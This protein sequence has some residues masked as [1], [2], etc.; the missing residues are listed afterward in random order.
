MW[1]VLQS[2]K[3]KAYTS[4]DDSTLS[5]DGHNNM[6]YFRQYF[7]AD[8]R[9]VVPGK[10]VHTLGVYLAKQTLIVLPGERHWTV[11][12]DLVKEKRA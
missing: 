2:G 9:K 4:K 12:Q 3:T 5:A 1:D 10:L 6:W 11:K 7:M 8:K